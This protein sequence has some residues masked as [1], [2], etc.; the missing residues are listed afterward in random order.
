MGRRLR[1]ACLC[2]LLTACAWPAHALDPVLMFVLSA[3]REVIAAAVRE[4]NRLPAP[5][6]APV[7]TPLPGDRYPGTSVHPEQLRGVV[8]ECFGYLS[9]AQRAEIFGSLHATLLDP[10]NAATRSAMIEYFIA[11]AVAVREAQQRL[12]QLSGAEEERLIAE[13]RAAV[14]AM[15][16]EEVEQLAELLRRRVL[17][18]PDDLSTKLIAAIDAR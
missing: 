10:K 17:P 11:R 15:P 4:K 7:P 9:E 16:R 2:V 18:V 5:A 14:A 6:P 1:Q 8:D 13:F 12:A 3:A